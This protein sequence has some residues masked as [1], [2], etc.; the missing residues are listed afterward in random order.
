MATVSIR[1]FP[2]KLGDGLSYNFR[3][4]LFYRCKFMLAG[5]ETIGKF[6]CPA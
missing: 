3:F 6:E 4:R 1:I 5:K 2:G